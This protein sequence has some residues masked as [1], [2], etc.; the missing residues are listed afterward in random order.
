M[1]LQWQKYKRTWYEA[2][3]VKSLSTPIEAVS[4]S[5]WSLITS[6]VALKFHTLSNTTWKIE[7]LQA[8]VTLVSSRLP[9][10]ANGVVENMRMSETF[11]ADASNASRRVERESGASRRDAGMSR[12][13]RAT[14]SPTGYN[15][16]RAGQALVALLRQPV[17][18]LQG[19]ER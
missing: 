7:S 9:L 6:I 14:F 11:A 19:K 13:A 10:N 5:Y 12:D 8:G 16:S 18:L 4:A 1:T 3:G 17:D 15:A 2:V